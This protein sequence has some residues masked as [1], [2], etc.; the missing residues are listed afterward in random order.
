MST[1]CRRTI[2][3]RQ[4]V[5]T[6]AAGAAATFAAP[7]IATATK[8]DSQ[9]IL[10]T[11]DYRYE[12]IHDWPQLPHQ[13]TWQ[14]THDV[15]I[16]REGLVYIIHEGKPDLPDH[17]AIFVFDAEGRFVRSFGQQ[18]QGGAHGLEVRNEGGEQFLYVCGYQPKTF[19]K[20]TLTGEIVWQRHAPM[21]SRLYADGE[22]A[23]SLVRNN[24]NNFMPTNFAFL[25]DHGFLLADGYGSYFIHRYDK[26]GQWLN[27]FGGPGD[28]DG[29]FNTPHGLWI[30]D[31]PGRDPT[32]VVTDR[33]HGK[34]QWFSL[35]GIH[36]HTLDGFIM[37]ANIDIQ[38]D[39]LLVPD[40]AARMTLLDRDNRVIAHLADDPA[41]RAE[42]MKMEIRKDPG[43]WPAG[44]FIHPHDACFDHEGN[45]F[46]AEFVEPGRIN[47]LRRL[48]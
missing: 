27:C 24:R 33:A 28:V 48:T 10:G 25:P 41:W 4:F 19:A 7:A 37:P 22:D 14:T 36:E 16:D 38:G 42:V 30:D 45:I 34:L 8:T 21:M 32:I 23:G 13:F 29:K 15:A 40:L 31:R 18:F 46:V 35:D 9:I 26:D 47:K 11:G 3:R 5:A 43:R 20:L 39:I 44:K 1:N 17:P 2:D 6:F 12:V